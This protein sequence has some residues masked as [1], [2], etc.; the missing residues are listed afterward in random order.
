LEVILGKTEKGREVMLQ[1]AFT[2]GVRQNNWK[3]I[4]PTME[5]HAWIMERKNIEGGISTEPQLYNLENDPGEKINLAA[6]F[7]DKV[8]E[9]EL[10]LEAIKKK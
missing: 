9:M 3:F 4:A 5:A 8:R 7:P 2:F 10:L 6:R 1:E